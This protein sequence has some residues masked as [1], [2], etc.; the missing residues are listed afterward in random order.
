MK[1]PKYYLATAGLLCSAVSGLAVPLANTFAE[2]ASSFFDLNAQACIIENYNSETSSS[3][4]SIGDV[5]FS[6]ITSLSCS[7]R[8]IT[9]F[10]GITLF[11]NLENLD[12]SY[13]SNLQV[14]NMDFSQNTKLKEINVKGVTTSYYDF[15]NNPDLET[16]TTDRSLTLKTIAYVE[17]TDDVEYEFDTSREYPYLMDTSVLR[18]VELPGVLHYSSIDD[19]PYTISETFGG[20]TH[21]IETRGGWMRYAVYLDGDEEIETHNPFYVNNNCEEVEDGY[22]SCNNS[23]YYGDTIDTDDIINNTLTKI[24]SLSEYTLS[25]VE[26]VPPTANLELTTDTDTVKRGIALADSNFTLEFYFDLQE[27]EEVKV[28]DTGAFTADNKGLI[29]GASVATITATG[30]IVAYLTRYATKRQKSK[31]RFSKN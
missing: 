14:W 7:N 13:N 2:G 4:A 6:E 10:R 30:L 8:N 3:V 15:S 12:I 27:A 21:Q 29:I 28:P 5:N 22:Y 25:K 31:V 1:T 11:P 16:I 18:F 20:Y 24:F 9:N 19:I 23:I 26:V 17:R